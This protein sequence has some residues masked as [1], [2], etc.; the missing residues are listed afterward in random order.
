MPFPSAALDRHIDQPVEG[1]AARSF[2]AAGLP[3]HPQPST[4]AAI[5]PARALE[6][7]RQARAGARNLLLEHEIGLCRRAIET[8]AQQYGARLDLRRRIGIAVEDA[9][10]GRA[11]QLDAPIVA[12]NMHR[13]ER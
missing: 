13:N 11:L 10:Q 9:R 4:D 3:A 8:L 7:L 6:R 2:A 1:E 5:G 12:G